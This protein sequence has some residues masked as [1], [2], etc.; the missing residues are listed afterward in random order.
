MWITYL[1]RNVLCTLCILF[2]MLLVNEEGEKIGT[3]PT[4][5]FLLMYISCHL[6]AVNCFKKHT[7]YLKL[8]SFS[9]FKNL[10]GTFNL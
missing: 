8:L 1:L 6:N 5:P 2:T 7:E 10:G 3:F 4:R 9:Y